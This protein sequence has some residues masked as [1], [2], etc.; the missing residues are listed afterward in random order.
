MLLPKPALAC[1]LACTQSSETTT[2]HVP[3][4]P[5]S[6]SNTDH[7]NDHSGGAGIA[8]VGERVALVLPGAGQVVVGVA[9]ERL[10]RVQDV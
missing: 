4:L 9:V 5:F 7:P 3:T 6:V 2:V 1:Q 10:Q 8:R